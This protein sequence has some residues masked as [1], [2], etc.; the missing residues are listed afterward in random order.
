MNCVK[1]ITL[2]CRVNQYESDAISELLTKEGIAIAKSE[3]EADAIIINTC[4]VTSESDA[5]CKKAIRRALRVREKTG[6]KVCVIGCYSQG[7]DSDPLL[8]RVDYVSGNRDKGEV[9]RRIKEILS[10]SK[11]DSRGT[12]SGAPYDNLKINNPRYVKAYVKIEDGCNNFCSYCYVPFVRGRV[13]SKSEDD[14]IDEITSLTHNGYKEIILSGIETGAFGEDSNKK[15]PLCSLVERIQRECPVDRLRFGSLNPS[16]FTEER[17]GR[18]AECHVM[19]HFHL[20]VQSASSDVLRDMRRGYDEEGLYLAVGNIKK[21]FPL[22]NISCDMI[23]GFP[24]EK[25]RDFEK[26]VEFIKKA[27]ILH[28]HIFPYS[29]RK[30]TL[31]SKME[32]EVSDR[33]K[34]LRAQEMTRVAGLVH[35][36]IFRENIGKEYRVLVEFFRSGV[37]F[38]YTENFISLKFP[39]SESYS[40]G[41]IVTLKIQDGMDNILKN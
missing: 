14:I 35:E 16:F 6:A 22:A 1:I 38:G 9:A 40:K 27:N 7:C 32:R 3:E 33:E 34:H 41:D 28:T 23:C 13:R 17:L 20:S 31:A 8:E 18:L 29:E 30:G 19:P 36:R 24:T 12:L 5:K 11:I 10:G 21:Y 26:S 37:A 25:E 4:T 39:Q 15:E 2:G